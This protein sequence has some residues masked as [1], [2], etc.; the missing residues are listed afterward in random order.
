MD[1]QSKPL[2]G[3]R[4]GIFGKGGAGKSTT[5]VLLAKAL[6]NQ[7]YEVCVLDA[8]STN[9]GLSQ[10]LGFPQVPRPLLDYFGGM[11]FQGGQVT[12]PVDDPTPLVGAEIALTDL[13]EE[14]YV[15]SAQGLTFLIAGKIGDQGPGAGCD[16]PI[17][18]I[19]R[20]FH[21][22]N[23]GGNM[24]TLIDFK[25]GF[26]DLARGVITGLDWALVV[27]DPT[28]A[29]IKMAGNFKEMVDR[30][31]AGELPATEHLESPQLVAMANQF[32]HQA[33]IKGV[34]VLLNKVQNQGMRQHMQTALLMQGIEPIGVIEEDRLLSSAWLN[35]D[36]LR[37]K[38]VYDAE[39]IVNA[40]EAVE[41]IKEIIEVIAA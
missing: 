28:L 18:K 27:V 17:A 13:P 34:L 40:L 22:S 8:D 36:P 23:P 1:N 6:L 41:E 30:I 14:Y 37:S 29:A 38:E 10:A 39:K 9:I 4:F 21:L 20:D 19:A 31:K 5:T 32:F 16:G 33:R 15:Q 26:E 11:V 24:I 12:C 7:G 3:L 2:S 35:G 25:A